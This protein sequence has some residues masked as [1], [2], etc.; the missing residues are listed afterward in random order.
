MINVEHL[1]Q[2][3][4]FNLQSLSNKGT[5]EIAHPAL[6]LLHTTFQDRK[7]PRCQAINASRYETRVRASSVIISIDAHIF[8]NVHIER[9]L[10]VDVIRN[11]HQSIRPLGYPFQERRHIIMENPLVKNRINRR[12]N[13]RLILQEVTQ[14][15][16]TVH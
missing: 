12:Q 7:C 14:R 9:F 13:E 10:V 1:W 16:E 11:P 3:K 4:G 6:T 8:I 5:L 2:Q 15:M